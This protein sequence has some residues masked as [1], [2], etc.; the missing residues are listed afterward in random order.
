MSAETNKPVTLYNFPFPDLRTCQGAPA[1]AVAAIFSEMGR[2]LKEPL[3]LPKEFCLS[4]PLFE[5]L[6]GGEKDAAEV[7]VLHR[8]AKSW[9]PFS[10]VGHI[11]LPK[12]NIKDHGNRQSSCR[13]K[14]SSKALLCTS[15]WE[16]ISASAGPLHFTPRIGVWDLDTTRAQ[17]IWP[18][19]IKRSCSKS[20]FLA[21]MAK[22]GRAIP[23]LCTVSTI[24]HFVWQCNPQMFEECCRLQS[25][26]LFSPCQ[27]ARQAPGSWT[28]VAPP[29]RNWEPL[30][31]TKLQS[32]EEIRIDQMKEHGNAC[33]SRTN[34]KRIWGRRQ[35]KQCNQCSQTTCLATDQN[36]RSRSLGTFCL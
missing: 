17:S 14:K 10:H 15:I 28:V 16:G 1:H 36:L 30:L 4:S 9:L 18:S 34:F 8:Q 3:F 23:I 13:G 35:E 7:E 29:P 20:Q 5:W 19:S 2:A 24:W 27:G 6:Q 22:L 32:G 25:G 21:K 26:V 31:S 11:M 33:H 12:P